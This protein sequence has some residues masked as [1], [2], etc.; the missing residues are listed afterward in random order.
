MH[1]RNR[2]L[3]SGAGLAMLL[4][5]SACSDAS[6]ETTDSADE[7]RSRLNATLGS[8][9]PVASSAPAPARRDVGGAPSLT[10]I[11]EPGTDHLTRGDGSPILLSALSRAEIEGADLAGELGCDFASGPTSVLLIAKGDVASPSSARGI[12][13]IGEF[14]E[15]VVAGEVGGFNAMLDG[16]TFV[17]QGKT[18]RIAVAKAAAAEGGES[19]PHRA[20]LTYQRADGAS[21]KLAGLWTCGP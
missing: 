16:T 9:N 11:K 10:G 14:V 2:R 18:I 15:P 6:R 21:R 7:G 5:T 12:V 13:K 19:P 4:V 1:F 20:T 8:K 17:G 3:T